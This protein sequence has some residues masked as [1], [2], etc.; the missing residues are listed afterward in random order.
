MLK[1]T[2]LA[3]FIKKERK[4]GEVKRT[5]SLP[6]LFK[7]DEAHAKFDNGVLTVTIPKEEKKKTQ[8][9]LD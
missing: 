4:Y 5:V 2:F 1:Q 3:L 7:I 6:Q 9:K 8:L